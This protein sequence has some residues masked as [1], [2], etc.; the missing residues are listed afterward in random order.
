MFIRLSHDGIAFELLIAMF[1]LQYCS[2]SSGDEVNCLRVAIC[3]MMVRC[4]WCISNHH[5]TIAANHH[6]TNSDT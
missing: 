4:Y 1:R 3:S 2:S 5:A 6:A